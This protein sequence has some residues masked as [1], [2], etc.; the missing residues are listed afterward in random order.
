V[1][2]FSTLSRESEQPAASSGSSKSE[3]SYRG[4]E[5]DRLALVPVDNPHYTEVAGRPRTE[6]DMARASVTNDNEGRE[7]DRDKLAIVLAAP[8]PQRDAPV[9]SSGGNQ[10]VQSVLL[11]LRQVKEQLRYTIQRRSE[12]FVAHRELYGH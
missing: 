5:E 3:A 1:E 12:G 8:Q 2:C 6:D 4:E 9:M 10:D 7:A 11:A